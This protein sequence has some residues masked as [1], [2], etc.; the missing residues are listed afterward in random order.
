M[1]AARQKEKTRPI[2]A[3]FSEVVSGAT[4]LAV[5]GSAP[6]PQSR[7]RPNL[8]HLLRR[9]PDRTQLRR[10]QIRLIPP[11]LRSLPLPIHPLPIRQNHPPLTIP[12]GRIRLLRLHRRGRWAHPAR[13]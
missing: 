3:G 6:R 1:E 5:F 9:T 13:G 11:P 8:L 2:L 12:L 4:A 7:L 10:R